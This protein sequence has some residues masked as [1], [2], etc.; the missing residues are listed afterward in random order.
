MTP[1]VLPAANPR[2][3]A[4]ERKT[5]RLVALHVPWGHRLGNYRPAGLQM[6]YEGLVLPS[7]ALRCV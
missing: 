1:S 7:L 4:D 3:E 2:G 5:A 6:F